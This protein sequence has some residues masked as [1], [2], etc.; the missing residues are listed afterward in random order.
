MPALALQGNTL[1]SLSAPCG[2]ES[3]GL[4]VTDPARWSA[5][6]SAAAGSGV[7]ADADPLGQQNEVPALALQG[8]IL[9]R[10]SPR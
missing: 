4:S 7:H 8:I 5:A 10:L 2:E 3:S 9:K 1:K 6:P